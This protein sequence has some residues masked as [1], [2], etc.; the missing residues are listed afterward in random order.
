MSVMFSIWTSETDVFYKVGYPLPEFTFNFCGPNVR[1][2]FWAM[3]GVTL[4]S[5]KVS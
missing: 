2:N 3:S 1:Q 4:D 5:N